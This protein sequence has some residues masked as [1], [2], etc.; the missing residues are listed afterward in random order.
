MDNKTNLMETAPKSNKDKPT[1]IRTPDSVKSDIDALNK[2]IANLKKQLE[3]KK[4][5]K[6]AQT[7]VLWRLTEGARPDRK[8]LTKEEKNEKL[9][10]MVL[11]R[12]GYTEND[13]NSVATS[14]V[15]AD[16]EMETDTESI[17]SEIDGLSFRDDIS[18]IEL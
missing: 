17:C 1:V 11:K 3:V 16:F 4:R 14:A 7:T 18:D 12:W 6:R 5:T 9:R 8:P 13:V 15:T 10:H 2:E